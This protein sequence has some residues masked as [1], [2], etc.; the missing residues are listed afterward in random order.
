MPARPTRCPSP[1]VAGPGAWTCGS[2]PGA[3]G[4]SARRAIGELGSCSAPARAGSV[5][6]RLDQ[7]YRGGSNE[8]AAT[9][10]VVQ[11]S[12]DVDAP[13]E[14]VWAIVSDPRNLPRW[15]RRIVAVDGVPAE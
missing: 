12:V 1:P 5:V 3:A 9:M 11:V 15:D 2:R 6:G 14:S 8:R 13:P 4:R 10:S 7:R